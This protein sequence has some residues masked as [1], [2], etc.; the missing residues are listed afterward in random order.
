MGTD[1]RLLLLIIPA[2][3]AAVEL[4]NYFVTAVLTPRPLAK[5]GFQRRRR[6]RDCATMVAIPTL[7]DQ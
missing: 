2:T 3:Q 7:A 6:S 4:M 1:L 5:I